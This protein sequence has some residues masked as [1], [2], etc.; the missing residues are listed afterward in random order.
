MRQIERLLSRK[1]IREITTLSFTQIDRLEREGKFPP[2]IRLTDH[3][4]GRVAWLETA[5]LDWI[6]SRI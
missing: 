4:R 3:P 2:R 6:N 1:Q 5:V